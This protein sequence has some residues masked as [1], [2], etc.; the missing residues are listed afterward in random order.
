MPVPPIIACVDVGYRG[1]DACAACVR[2]ETRGQAGPAEKH[3]VCTRAGGVY[4]AGSFYKR[5]LAPLLA[6]LNSV[7]L[8]MA[9]MLSRSGWPP[10][11]PPG[12]PGS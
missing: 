11:R 5:E 9:D 3:I 1:S 2:I 6:V 10:R 8:K 12:S 7:L 4:E